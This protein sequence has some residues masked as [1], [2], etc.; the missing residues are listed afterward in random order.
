MRKILLPILLVFSISVQAQAPEDALRFSFYPQNGTARN[1]AV[2]GAMGSLGGDLNALFV[3]PA[4]LGFFKTSEFVLTPGFILNNNKANFRQTNSA[5]K[6]NAFSYGTSGWVFGA[7]DAY[8]PKSSSAFSIGITQTANF[9][10]EVK[11]RGLNNFS[12]FSEQYAEE[13][14]KSGLTIEQ[15]LSFQTPYPYS[16]A[17]ALMSYLIDTVKIN[18]VYKIMAA[19]EFIL[20]AGG[21]IQQ[22]FSQTSSGGINELALGFAH[23]KDD[24]WFIGGSIGIPII[25][26]HSITNVTESDTSS[27][28]NNHFSRFDYMDDL[29]THGWGL[30]G[31]FGVIYRPKEY[32]RLG[33]SIQTPSFMFLTD[34]RTT[35]FNTQLE[36]PVGN[37]TANSTTFT[38]D[39]PGESKYHQ[40]TP[41]KAIISGSYVFRE[42]SNVKKQR[43]FLTADIEYVNHKGSRFKSNN[44][45]ATA[46]EKS[47]YTNLNQVVSSDYKGSFNFR[48]GGELKFNTIMGRLG[49]AY[50]SNPYQ[51]AA[52]KA[53]RMLLS[54]GLGYRNK[55]FFIDLTYV[56]CISKDVQFPYR[57][58]DRA[59]TYASLDQK[60][61]NVMATVG[62][63]F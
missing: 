9:N 18:G 36:N 28:A 24:R 10:N 57:L 32:I 40:N 46:D 11:Y 30:N 63:K 14:A 51:D 44:K 62:I 37:F 1:L 21:A 55:G 48:V 29:S 23:N 58:E 39:Q 47:Y 60:R 43:A 38:N 7:A 5:N 19:P 17:P 59:N 50:Y 42:L 13:F 54:G 25:Q 26:Y 34:K 53:S 12:S 2:G 35:R 6:S 31:K 41:F 22:E 56:H 16:T 8:H 61:G 52:L 15:A 4:G 45:G 33:L 49:F 27:N 3:N 20:N